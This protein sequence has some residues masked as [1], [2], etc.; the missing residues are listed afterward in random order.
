M[1]EDDIE[2]VTYPVEEDSPGTDVWG[3]SEGT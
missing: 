2:E 1:E 3:E